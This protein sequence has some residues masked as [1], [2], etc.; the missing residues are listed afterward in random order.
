MLEAKADAVWGKDPAYVAYKRSTWTLM[1]W[2]P[3]EN[4]LKAI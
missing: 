4:K 3:T 2:P 1:L